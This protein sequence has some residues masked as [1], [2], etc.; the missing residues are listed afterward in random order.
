M[1]SLDASSNGYEGSAIGIGFAFRVRDAIIPNLQLKLNKTTIA[2][3]Y[4]INISG[5]SAAGYSRQGVELMI[6]QKLN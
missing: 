5:L 4:D 2:L 1:H 6:S 3:H